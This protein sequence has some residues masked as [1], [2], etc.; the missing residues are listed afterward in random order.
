MSAPT[1]AV[2]A[3]A[4]NSTGLF[5]LLEWATLDLFFQLRPSEPIDPRIVIVT[6]DESD[7][8]KIGQ[9]PIPDAVL[10]EAIENIKQQQPKVI[11][12][13]LYRD[14][15]VEPGHAELVQVFE[16][17][18]NLIGVEKVVGGKVA[19]PEKLQE[20]NQV[21]IAD[22]VID[23]DGKVRRGLLSVKPQNQSTRLSLAATVSLR[24][25][26]SQGISLEMVDAQ[27]NHLGLGKAV[28]IPLR[29]NEGGYINVDAGGYQ[30][31]INYRGAEE[32]FKT[33]S[34]TEVLE[35]DIPPDLMRDRIVLIGGIAESL[36]DLFFTP[37]SG[38]N[39]Q[40]PQRTPG[41]VIH[42]NVIS[43]ILSGAL[44]ARPFITFLPER[45]EWLWTVICSLA[46]A[47][48]SYGL[49][50][51]KRFK[52]NLSLKWAIVVIWI[53]A[54]SSGL[55]GASYLAF[56]NSYWIPVV[57]PIVGLIG[58]SVAM[59]A[60]YSRG[61]QRESERRLAQFLEAMPVGIAVLDA[62]GKPYYTNK[63]AE[64]LL[65]K[66][67]VRSANPQRL[68]EVY[69]YYLAGTDSLYP[70]ESLPIIRALKGETSTADDIEIHRS[71]RPS[72][73]I[74][75][76]GT[77]IYDENGNIS[78]A[79]VAFQDITERK[80]AEADRERF[81]KE[82]F[83]LNADLEKALDAEFELTDAYGRFVPHE[84][85][86]F[87]GYE[88][89]V[90]VKLG[91]AVEMEMSILFSDIR[92]F[93]TLS[94]SMTPQENFKFIN[95]YLSCMEP[96]IGEHRGFIDKYI[97]DAIMALF[98]EGADNAVKAAI[99]M[100][101]RLHKYNLERQ[102]QGESPI[103]IG[104]GINT[105]SLMLGTVGGPKRMDGTVISDAVNLA[106]RIEGLTKNYGLSLLISDRTFYSLQNS[107]HYNIRLIDR[108]KVKGK[109]ETV[110]V[111]EVFD[112]DPIELRE[113]K[114]ITQSI[115]EEALL[116]YSHQ[117]YAEA[118]RLFQ[119][120]LRINPGDSVARIYLD[121]TQHYRF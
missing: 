101:Q 56:L 5:Q 7:I 111:F 4:L 77:P 78:Y 35:N 92:D 61:V 97:G 66:G 105:G 104:I 36:N 109:S 47:S 53:G 55:M 87:L 81:T 12:M 90:A 30:I 63:T 67:V 71:D 70:W 48:I 74:E 72:I 73:P 95:S 112:A 76:W 58:S 28:F 23:K 118:H 94:E 10:A 79:L 27:Q 43:Q 64:E 37:F 19:A 88:S 84:F 69:Q 54:G 86:H 65:G 106:S 57:A 14:L 85:L 21:A 41:V 25:L 16:S 107:N 31:L 9:W 11:G 80:Q 18:P 68:A 8:T 49:L 113:G 96:A 116:H 40:S 34:M 59:A 1:V 33:V 50:Q 60:Y 103:K 100:L 29:G 99:A 39:S 102:Q 119:K 120:C 62:G 44:E 108:V 22:L 98:G 26:E 45:F 46:G 51:T 91:E 114:L 83:A 32:N 2:V 115:F 3:I 117:H 42:A 6:I 24:V 121:R 13:D 15:P 89:I 17:T 75:A 52:P 20:L 110:S 93:T 82:L 38:R